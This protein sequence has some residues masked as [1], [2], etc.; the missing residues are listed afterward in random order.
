MAEITPIE[1]QITSMS[2][3]EYADYLYYKHLNDSLKTI[4]E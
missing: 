4:G 3:T 2:D 1:I